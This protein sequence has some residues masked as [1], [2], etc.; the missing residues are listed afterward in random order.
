MKESLRLPPDAVI[1]SFRHTFES[2]L[3]KAGANSFTIVGAMGQST[4]VVSQ[5]YMDPTPQEMER[6][7]ERLKAANEKTL[8]SL[9]RNP[10]LALP[11]T[12][13]TTPGNGE[14]EALAQVL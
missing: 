2:W 4:V 7:L 6:G 1:H 11:A 10:K 5:K 12:V 9:E 3:G 14:S 8:A 13:S